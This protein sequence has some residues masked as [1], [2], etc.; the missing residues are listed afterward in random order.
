MNAII[1][2]IS[3]DKGPGCRVVLY[4]AGCNKDCKDCNAPGLKD[5]AYKDALKFDS[6]MIKN[7]LEFS[8][9]DAIDGITISGGE[10]M[11]FPDEIFFIIKKFM[12]CFPEK[13]IWLYTGYK[14]EDIIKVPKLKKI[15][16]M[17]DVVVDG[18]FE[19]ANRDKSYSF[20]GSFNERII[21]VANTLAYKSIEIWDPTEY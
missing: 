19:A 21:D 12:Q 20:K 7:I 4:V 14:W 18:E 5:F 1:E 2:E 11:L 15:A 6:S 10:P 16:Y 17:C 13:T 9:D 8:K 3:A